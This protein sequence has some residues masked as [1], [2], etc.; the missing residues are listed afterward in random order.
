[1]ATG[2]YDLPWG[3]SVSG[4]GEI[5]SSTNIDTILGLPC[6]GPVC[7]AYGGNA[8]P[9]SVKI[10]NAIGYRDLDLSLAKK[11]GVWKD[12]KAVVRFDLLNVF[13][14]TNYD[15]GSATWG[16]NYPNIVQPHYL[17]NGPIVGFPRTL[18]LTGQITW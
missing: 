12:V 2:S 14:Y 16:P 17:A 15:P 6:P 3:F 13:N 4:K 1:V 11:F 10:P 7:N 5:S 9:I 8:T 18:K